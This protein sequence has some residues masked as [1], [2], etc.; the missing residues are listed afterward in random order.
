MQAV[1]LLTWMIIIWSKEWVWNVSL[2]YIQMIT[3]L[4]RMDSIVLVKR[5]YS[6]IT[7]SPREGKKRFWGVQAAVYAK[8]GHASQWAS[9][10]SVQLHTSFD[11]YNTSVLLS[12]ISEIE[13]FLQKEERQLMDEQPF[14]HIYKHL[15]TLGLQMGKLITDLW[16]AENKY[17]KTATEPPEGEHT[18]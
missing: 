16:D 4:L 14:I 17:C 6:L 15:A 2:A 3:I 10:E 8:E 12:I 9:T 5:K 11:H 7:G 13:E 18:A 1:H